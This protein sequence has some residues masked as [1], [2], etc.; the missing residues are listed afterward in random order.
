MIAYPYWVDTRLVG[1]NAGYPTKD[2]G[3]SI[4]EIADTH[5][6]PHAK[7]FILN[8]QDSAAVDELRRQ[9]S[10]GSLSEYHSAVPGKSF[11]M[12]QVPPGSP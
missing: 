10:L 11:L 7:L 1:I 8:K 4:A 3:I 9:Y 6:D 5:A 2:Y 12:Y